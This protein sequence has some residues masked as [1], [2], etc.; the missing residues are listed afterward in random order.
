MH[1]KIVVLTQQLGKIAG[2]GVKTQENII[3]TIESTNDNKKCFY[4]VLLI[5]EGIHAARFHRT[6]WRVANIKSQPALI[7]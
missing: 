2:S 1:K 7:F 3:R 5:P 6:K 4:Y